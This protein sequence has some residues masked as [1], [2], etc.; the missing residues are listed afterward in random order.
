MHKTEAKNDEFVAVRTQILDV[1]IIEKLVRPLA[2]FIPRSITPNQITMVTPVLTT[3]CFVAAALAPRAE[4]KNQALMYGIL[5][6]IFCVGSM[7]TDHLDGMHARDTGQSS[8]LGEIL[9]HWVDSYSVTLLVMAFPVSMG[10]TGLLV[11][12]GVT[13]GAMVY[14]TQLLVYRETGTFVYPPSGGAASAILLAGGLIVVALILRFAPPEGLIDKYFVDGAVALMS[15]GN[16]MNVAY[17]WRLLRR[18]KKLSLPFLAAYGVVALLYGLEL[19]SFWPTALLWSSLSFRMSGSLV[20][21]TVSKIPYR[22]FDALLLVL[23]GLSLAVGGLGMFGF[24]PPS[25]TEW[26]A[27]LVALY[28]V[29]W[30][31]AEFRRFALVRSEVS[32]S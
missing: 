32:V 5:A 25:W 23:L 7:I 20:L 4:T 28:A 6:A 3:L 15:L 24:V 8:K 18:D 1:V 22:G 16:L 27:I 13:T 19:L 30:N 29:L 17:Y 10:A 26:S 21:F 12:L 11:S 14:H 9:D 31:V 2:A